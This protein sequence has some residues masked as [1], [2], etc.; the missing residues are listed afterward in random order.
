MDKLTAIIPYHNP[1]NWRNRFNIHQLTVASLK[2]QNADVFVIQCKHTGDNLLDESVPHWINLNTNKLP[3]LVTREP[4]PEIAADITVESNSV[5]WQKE[6]L[7]NVALQHIDSDYVAWIDNDLLF[8]DKD[9]VAHTIDLLQN[10]DYVHLFKTLKYLRS[11][12]RT[13]EIE[14]IGA[15]AEP[16]ARNCPGG[17]WAATRDAM[18]T[19][20]YDAHITGGGD[21]FFYSVI[22]ERCIGLG[23][24]YWECGSRAFRQHMIKWAEAHIKQTPDPRVTYLD[25]SI[26]HLFHG[27]MTDRNYTGRHTWLKKWEYDPNTDIVNS[28]GAWKWNSHKPELHKQLSDYFRSRNE[29]IYS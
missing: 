7:I 4:L 27:T 18:K 24:A 15:V 16:S 19:G 3:Q 14:K 13:V 11:D 9:W 28:N 25:Q 1:C 20:L 8:D 5:L 2:A 22:F 26:Y 23:Y 29:D 12:N 21:S 17:A 6:R 10:N